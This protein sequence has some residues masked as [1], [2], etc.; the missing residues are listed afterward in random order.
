MKINVSIQETKIIAWRL[1]RALI[2]LH[3]DAS[4][5]TQSLRALNM[6]LP[7]VIAEGAIHHG[8]VMDGQIFARSNEISGWHAKPRSPTK[9]TNLCE[10]CLFVFCRKVVC[11]Q[12]I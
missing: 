2:C 5:D 12:K 9:N 1:S 4:R 10:V 7:R 11:Y 6:Q 3:T 8:V